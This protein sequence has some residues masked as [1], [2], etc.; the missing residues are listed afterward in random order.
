MLP[1]V[2]S[3]ELVHPFKF[4]YDSEICEGMHFGNE[5]YRLYMTYKVQEQQKTFC[6]KVY[7]RGD[8]APRPNL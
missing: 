5:L 2:L 1:F 3:H 8:R 6:Y 7:L 4:W